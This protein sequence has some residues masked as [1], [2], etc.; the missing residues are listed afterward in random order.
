[1]DIVEEIRRDRESGAKR[2]ET[3]YKAG[4]MTLARRFCHDTGDAELTGSMTGGAV[5]Q[6]SDEYRFDVSDKAFKS[7][8]DEEGIYLTLDDM[9]W[10]RLNTMKNA[11]FDITGPLLILAIM[12]FLADIALRRFGYEPVFRKKKKV[13]QT[14]APE[15]PVI[16]EEPVV[17]EVQ[18]VKEVKAKKKPAKKKKE[19]EVE[20]ELDTSSLLK[21]KKD[22]NL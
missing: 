12:L 16:T 22:R 14:A 4:L 18:E 10:R 6:Y 9:V 8:V 7:F 19:A 20:E 21:R 2:L 5:V 3:E 17:E 1:M 13:Q 15:E 11:R